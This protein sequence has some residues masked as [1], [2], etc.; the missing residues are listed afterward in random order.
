MEAYLDMRGGI[1]FS[2][3]RGACVKENVNEIWRSDLSISKA[4][5]SIKHKY[6]AK[7]KYMSK[8]I[9]SVILLKFKDYLLIVIISWLGRDL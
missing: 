2:K 6:K 8:L 7:Y 1:D 5:I 9:T 4:N 3:S